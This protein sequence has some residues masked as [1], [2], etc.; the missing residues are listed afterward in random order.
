MSGFG[1]VWPLYAEL[2][3]LCKDLGVHTSVAQNL[4]SVLT[5]LGCEHVSDVYGM[6]LER[7]AERRGIGPRALMIARSIGAKDAV[8]R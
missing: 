8:K 7:I 1:T 6:P 5:V 4:A 2:H 3:A